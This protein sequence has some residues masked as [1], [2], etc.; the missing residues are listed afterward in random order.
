[1]AQLL[2]L[3]VCLVK[4]G[5]VWYLPEDTLLSYCVCGL[6][7]FLKRVVDFEIYGAQVMSASQEVRRAI[8]I[9]DCCIWLLK[10]Q[11]CWTP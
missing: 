8:G 5:G 9:S 10:R 3:Q 4:L 2:H 1:M 7:L 6:G 11:A